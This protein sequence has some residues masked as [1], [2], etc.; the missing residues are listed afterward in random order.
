MT[1]M[2]VALSRAILFFMC[3]NTLVMSVMYPT[4]IKDIV[5]RM[6]QVTQKALQNR[7]SRME[8]EL[9]PTADFG[10]E[11]AKNPRNAASGLSTADQIKRSNRESARLFTEMFSSLSS[12]T[13]VLFPTETEASTARNLWGAAFRGTFYDK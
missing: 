3:F 9:P 7:H 8:V 12:T 13:A 10:V 1:P 2:W 6:T 4:K 11:S 5:S